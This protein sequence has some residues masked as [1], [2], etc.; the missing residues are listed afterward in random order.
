MLHF[1][2]TT[3]DGYVVSFTQMC[4]LP[5]FM[6]VSG[7]DGL[8]AVE[9]GGGIGLSALVFVF[10]PLLHRPQAHSCAP[11]PSCWLYQPQGTKYKLFFY[12]VLFWAMVLAMKVGNCGYGAWR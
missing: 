11:E 3:R 12:N 1:L 6:K 7:I 9:K 2:L 4:S 5:N 10:Y 8:D